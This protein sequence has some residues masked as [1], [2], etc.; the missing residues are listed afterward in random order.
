MLGVALFSSD[1]LLASIALCVCARGYGPFS[2][3]CSN[4]VLNHI[5]VLGCGRQAP[6]CS[7][8]CALGDTYAGVGNVCVRANCKLPPPLRYYAMSGSAEFSCVGARD[9]RGHGP[10]YRPWCDVSDTNAGAGVTAASRRARTRAYVRA[11]AAHCVG[12]RADIMPRKELQCTLSLARYVWSAHCHYDTVL[13][14]WFACK[15][16]S[17]SCVTGSRIA[18]VDE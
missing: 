13:L 14:R 4:A 2:P 9:R 7:S 6:L 16:V 10:M 12:F 1:L 8:R 18:W 15:L 17:A 3:L 11:R 5:G